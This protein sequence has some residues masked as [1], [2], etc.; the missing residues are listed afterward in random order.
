[1]EVLEVCGGGEG[2]GIEG[3]EHEGTCRSFLALST[4]LELYRVKLAFRCKTGPVGLF[5]IFS[6]AIFLLLVCSF[7]TTLI[8]HLEF[9]H[10]QSQV[11]KSENIFVN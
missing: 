10:E 2:L 11:V 4:F 8:L 1:M 9:L 7:V 5:L 6:V 3:P